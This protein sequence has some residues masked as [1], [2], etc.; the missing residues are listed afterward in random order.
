[1]YAWLLIRCVLLSNRR[2]YM[3]SVSQIAKHIILHWNYNLTKELFWSKNAIDS[4]K[5]ITFDYIMATKLIILEWKS[6]CVF[7]NKR[8]WLSRPIC[9]NL[10]M[11]FYSKFIHPHHAL[12]VKK[13]QKNRIN[14]L[15]WGEF[16]KS[17]C[18]TVASSRKHD[19]FP[20]RRKYIK[21]CSFVRRFCYNFN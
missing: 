7:I 11:N 17:I 4:I 3:Y 2:V 20:F 5:F 8:I 10:W 21:F 13:K 12:L 19:Q 9:D 1:M 14:R 16:G 6:L 18:Q 15:W